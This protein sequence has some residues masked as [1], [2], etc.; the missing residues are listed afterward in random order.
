[1]DTKRAAATGRPNLVFDVVLAVLGAAGGWAFVWFAQDMPGLKTTDDVVCDIGAVLTVTRLLTVTLLG[2]SATIYTLAAYRR[3]CLVWRPALYV[4]S[5]LFVAVV[6]LRLVNAGLGSGFATLFR[7]TANISGAITSG[8]KM[9]IATA[10]TGAAGAALW[11]RLGAR[12][13]KLWLPHP[14][15]LV[16]LS[17]AMMRG[18]PAAGLAL[19]LL[20][21]LAL[22]LTRLTGGTHLLFPDAVAVASA[23]RPA[24]L[25]V[26]V[27]A[28]VTG[29]VFELAFRLFAAGAFTAWTGMPKLSVIVI[30][31][32]FALAAPTVPYAP[33]WL[34]SPNSSAAAAMF[35]AGIVFGSVA[36]RFG[37]A[38]SVSASYLLTAAL[39][40]APLIRSGDTLQMAVAILILSVPLCISAPGAF[41][42]IKRWRAARASSPLPA[43]M[44]DIVG[45]EAVSKI[46]ALREPR[47]GQPGPSVFLDDKSVLVL[48]A[49]RGEEFLG[50]IAVRKAE[51]GPSE[52]LDVF[53]VE[54]ERRQ[55]L[56]SRLIN[57][58]REILK[59]EGRRAIRATI[60]EMDVAAR[61]FFDAARFDSAQ[62]VV[63]SPSAGT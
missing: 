12:R 63:R 17:A 28:L 24:L 48:T 41:V 33:A 45:K 15:P 59:V 10:L 26:F 27:A 8:L 5:A 31:A 16:S 34:M 36:L 30:A 58:A 51:T 61:A 22:A 25:F 62:V 35:F 42:A 57:E 29:I 2:I 6:A 47:P 13:S 7:A 44:I 43:V 54:G 19:G 21:A 56:G 40:G 18:Y 55:Y 23:G 38:A 52:L 46:A 37:V 9:L 20:T 11:R 32:V 3:G 1:M 4:G 14:R 53:V 60:D 50:Y 49:R 39:L